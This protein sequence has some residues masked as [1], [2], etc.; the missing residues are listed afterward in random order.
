MNTPLISMKLVRL[1]FKAYAQFILLT[2]R[3]EEH[4]TAK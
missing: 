1:P 4:R 3:T 2:E